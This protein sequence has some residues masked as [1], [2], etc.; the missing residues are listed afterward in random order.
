M[1]YFSIRRFGKPLALFCIVTLLSGC[2]AT[3]KKTETIEDRVNGRWAALLAKEIETA[4]NYLTPG[5]RS[6]VSLQQYERALENQAVKWTSAEYIK[7]E[8]EES[9]CK[10]KVQVGYTVYGALPGVK[11]YSTKNY[12]DETWI[13]VDGQWYMVP[14][15]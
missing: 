13:L 6:S 2:A 11:S 4:Y 7:S 3:V 15:R 9:T 5:Y 10:V 8:C 14:P 12:A 1:R